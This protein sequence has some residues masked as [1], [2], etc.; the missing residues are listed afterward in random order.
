M[1]R[2][3]RAR[4]CSS[5]NRSLLFVDADHEVSLRG[6]AL[7]V[8]SRAAQP[9][10]LAVSGLPLGRYRDVVSGAEVDL[11]DQLAV[12]PLTAALWLP[13]DDA[14]WQRLQ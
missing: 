5:G 6:S 3:G 10:S 2:L 13:V 14:C 11:A 4:G 7:S 1:A 9:A 8:L 12:A